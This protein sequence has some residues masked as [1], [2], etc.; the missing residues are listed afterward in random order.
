MSA[1]NDGIPPTPE[2]PDKLT[3]QSDTPDPFYAIICA[4]HNAATGLTKIP[5]VID[6]CDVRPGMAHFANRPSRHRLFRLRVLYW[7]PQVPQRAMPEVCG[8]DTR[9]ATRRRGVTA[10]K[11]RRPSGPQRQYREL[12]LFRAEVGGE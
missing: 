3:E 10:E 8:A 12:S 7:R 6:K 4:P 1:Q 2:E 11:S 9:P 5:G